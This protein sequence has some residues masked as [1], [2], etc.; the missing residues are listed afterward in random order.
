MQSHILICVVQHLFKAFAICKTRCVKPEK[1]QSFETELHAIDL[2][3][4]EMDAHSP[5]RFPIH[6][7]S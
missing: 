3:P 2:I 7:F 4:R 5:L 1:R 6:S